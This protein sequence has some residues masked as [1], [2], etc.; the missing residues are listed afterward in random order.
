MLQ[1]IISYIDKIVENSNLKLLYEELI[2]KFSSDVEK[3]EIEFIMYERFGYRYTNNLIESTEEKVK[4][5]DK[6]FRDKV[7]TYYKT[8][9]ITGRTSKVCDVTH[10]K[11]FSESK[12]EEKYDPNN[13]LLLSADLHKLFDLKLL[14]INSDTFE[15]KLAVE[16][17]LNEEFKDYYQ[18]N[19]K[20]IKIKK[21]SKKYLNQ[22]F[23]INISSVPDAKNH[24][25]HHNK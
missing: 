3:I 17:L 13:G 22:I 1:D 5:K 18:F 21:E 2:E 25:K 4:R 11:P 19:G 12:P 16:V 14:T 7:R 9:V 6:V 8:C 20:I 24:K 15:I 23:P 10:I